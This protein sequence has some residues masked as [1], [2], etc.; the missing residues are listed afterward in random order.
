MMARRFP[1]KSSCA[2]TKRTIA[3]LGAI[4][5]EQQTIHGVWLHGGRRFDEENVRFSVDIEDTAGAAAFFRRWKEV[6]KE[7]F[8]QIDIWIVSYEIRLT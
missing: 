6:L 3:E 4:S 2:L 1:M 8:R 7:R 5:I